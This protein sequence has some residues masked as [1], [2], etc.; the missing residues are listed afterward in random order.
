MARPRCVDALIL[1]ASPEN[2]LGRRVRTL[3]PEGPLETGG[4]RIGVGSLLLLPEMLSK[5]RREGSTEELVALAG[6]LA[7]LDPA[8]D[9]RARVPR[10][11]PPN[12]RRRHHRTSRRA[13]RRVR[14]LVAAFAAIPVLSCGADEAQPAT[15][16]APDVTTFEPGRFDDLPLH[17]RSDPVGERTESDGVSSRSFSVRGTTPREVLE[18]YER[19]LPERGWTAVGTVEETGPSAYQGDWSAE[20]WTLRVSANDASGLDDGNDTSSSVITQYSFVLSPE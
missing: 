12:M 17:P 11:K 7:R 2:I 18:F 6:L 14:T 10:G 8:V 4:D 5:P 16:P 19:V 9:V 3:F 1:A 20:E 15:Q 13:G